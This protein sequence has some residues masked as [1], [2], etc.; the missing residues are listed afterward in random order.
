[1]GATNIIAV[2]AMHFDCPWWYRIGV[3]PMGW[4]APR[5]AAPVRAS[6]TVIRPIRPLGHYSQAL[7]WK[8]DRIKSWIERGYED[9]RY[10]L[11]TQTATSLAV[12]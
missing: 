6:A 5:L 11:S 4:F 7:E 10:K 9:A 8:Q 2:D 3:S 12:A 1:M